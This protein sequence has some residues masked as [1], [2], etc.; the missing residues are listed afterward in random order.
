MTIL[1]K[2]LNYERPA[3]DIPWQVRIDKG[4]SLLANPYTTEYA[5]DSERQL[6]YAR[7]KRW[8]RQCCEG[9]GEVLPE[10]FKLYAIHQNFGKLELFCWCAPKLCH[11]LVIKE[12]LELSL[13][14][15]IYDT[16]RYV[17][18]QYQLFDTV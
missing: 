13:C 12:F 15:G 14:E 4:H 9:T 5:N 3:E 8:L 10:L 11:G 6:S 2:N 1:L 18:G 16:K 17:K 7:Y